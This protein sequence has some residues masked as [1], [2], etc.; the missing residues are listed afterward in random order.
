MP[1]LFKHN[2]V[3]AK[4]E[5][6]IFE[7]RDNSGFVVYDCFTGETKFSLTLPEQ[8]LADSLQYEPKNNKD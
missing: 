4:S 1:L 6:V 7:A 5:D 3:K 8:E 2:N